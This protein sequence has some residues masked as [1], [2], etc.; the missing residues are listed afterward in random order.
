MVACYLI[1][2][3]AGS[4]A[5]FTLTFLPA[6]PANFSVGGTVLADPPLGGQVYDVN[7]DNNFADTCMNMVRTLACRR[8]GSGVLD[9]AGLVCALYYWGVVVTREHVPQ[10]EWHYPPR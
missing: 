3:I 2:F 8:G 10:Q 4:T 6:T 7:P 5:N 1:D 9:R